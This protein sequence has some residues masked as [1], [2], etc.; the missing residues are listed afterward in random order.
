MMV[1]RPSCCPAS[2]ELRRA[3]CTESRPGS[4]A[5]AIPRSEDLRVPEQRVSGSQNPVIFKVFKPQNPHNGARGCLGSTILD[6][7]RE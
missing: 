3:P 2:E 4:F 1:Y 7:R 5:L 6:P